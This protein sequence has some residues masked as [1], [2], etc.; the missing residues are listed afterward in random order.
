MT[1]GNN[2]L[3]GRSF[4]QERN[5]MPQER[6]QVAENTVGNELAD[7]TRAGAEAQESTAGTPLDHWVA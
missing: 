4:Q 6:A 2:L 1:S 5:N 7:W 3:D